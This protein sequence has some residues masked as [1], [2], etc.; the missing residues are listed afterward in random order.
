VRH[1][2]E[3]IEDGVVRLDRSPEVGERDEGAATKR[4]R[5]IEEDLG[6]SAVPEEDTGAGRTVGWLPSLSAHI[7]LTT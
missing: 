3:G 7:V 1:C 4:S 2:R 5:G 6:R